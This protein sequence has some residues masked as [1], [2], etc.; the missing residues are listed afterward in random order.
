MKLT[1]S[2]SRSVKQWFA[3]VFLAMSL[4]LFIIIIPIII[5]LKIVFTNLQ[6]EKYQQQLNTGTT[7][8]ESTVSGVL[9]VAHNIA[10]D[11]RF[12]QC[13]YTYPD[14]SDVS[15]VVRNQLKTT[16]SALMTP[17]DNLITDSVLQFEENVAVT[18]N[19]VSFYDRIPFYPRMFQVDDFDYASWLA[20]LDEKQTGFLPA[21]NIRSSSTQ[22]S[23]IIYSVPMVNNSFFYTCWNVKDIKRILISDKKIDS[24]YLTLK[25]VSGNVLYND[26]PENAKKCRELT[27]N[28][29]RGGLQ[30]SILVPN[31]IF[32]QQ[33]KPLIVFLICY[34]IVYIAVLIVTVF[35]GASVS[36]KPIVSILRTLEH[37]NNLIRESDK[38]TSDIKEIAERNTPK[39]SNS[40]EIA[41][42]HADK[43]IKYYNDAL[44]T[45]QKLLQTR[46]FE[47]ALIG[48]LTSIS[49]RERFYSYFPN[50]PLRYHLL[51]AKICCKNKNDKNAYVRIQLIL[52]S[53]LQRHIKK[54]FYQQLNEKEILLLVDEQEFE[55]GCQTMNLIMDNIHKEDPFVSI[56]CTASTMFQNL[57]SLPAA[58]RQLQDLDDYSTAECYTHVY[59]V[60][61]YKD[62]G[63]SAFPMTDILSLYTAITY[64]NE[65]TALAKLSSCFNYE[66]LRSSQK[67]NLYE[68]ISALLNCIKLEHPELL[69][70]LIIPK[71][72]SE[73]NLQEQLNNLIHEFCIR[74]H[75]ANSPD[76]NFFAIQVLQYI[77]DHY[78]DPDLCIVSLSETFQCSTSKLQKAVKKA[79]N[80]T[81]SSYIEKRR[82]EKA[83][84]LL[85]KKQLPVAK[86][87]EECGFSS[88]NSFYKAYR[89]V[90]GHAPTTINESI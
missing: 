65:S 74:I 12:L 66:T 7:Q 49:D 13:Q 90:Y 64:G 29:S 69:L 50:F 42:L 28:T 67:R 89:R 55:T 87:A 31:E 35:T 54:G 76:P 8:I 19:R 1:S 30:I 85:A 46:F 36:S 27:S 52:K 63:G 58:Y 45:Q 9:N 80:I 77:D 11:S 71:Y 43:S 15:I 48:Q 32:N 23:A 44:A 68:I 26:S 2:S 18:T 3:T 14:Y 47:K 88:A 78:M 37:C 22:Y 84:E 62:C 4:L 17:F 72:D 56:Q 86:I 75:E 81:L 83:E 82:M 70:E 60:S 41:L 73:S 6:L 40:I 34:C 53:F 59:T 51:R 39:W 21:H 38:S 33:M 5:Y 61:D 16:L 79:A 20:K 10:A 57:D 24:I 25:D